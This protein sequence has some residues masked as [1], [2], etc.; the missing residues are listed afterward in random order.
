MR[1]KLFLIFALA[2]MLAVMATAQTKTSGTV[3]CAKPEPAY[4]IEVG[5]RPGHSISISKSACTWTTPMD[6]AG[7][8]TKAGYDVTYGDASGAKVRGS[9]YHVSNMSNG[10]K[11]Y[12]R[13]QGN[14][15]PN[16]TEGTWSYT[17]GTGKLKGIKGKGTYKGKADASGNMIVAVDGDYELP[18]AKK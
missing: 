16:T 7:L 2:L 5:D 9:G 8:Q 17:G 4:S 12:V 10:D 11:I 3:S 18:A 6:I 15:T 14:D 1:S 13:F